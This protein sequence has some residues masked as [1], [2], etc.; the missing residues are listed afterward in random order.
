[1]MLKEKKTNLN[2]QELARVPASARSPV[3]GSG[4]RETDS[5]SVNHHGR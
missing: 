3:G 2:L 4:L 1:M 5:A